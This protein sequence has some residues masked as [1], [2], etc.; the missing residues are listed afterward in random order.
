MKRKL[1]YGVF[2][3]GALAIL[4][5]DIA[6]A[7]ADGVLTVGRQ[8]DSNNLDP[9]KAAENVNLWVFA[10][11]YDVLIRVDPTGTKL[12]PGLAESWTVSDD[13]LT[14]TLKL[15]DAKFSDGSPITAED[16]A[17][18]LLRIRDHKESAWSASYSVIKDAKAA[19]DKTL[20]VTLNQPTAP[21]L[22]WLAMPSVGITQKKSVEANEAV[23]NDHPVSSG[24][25]IL[26]EWRKGERLRLE[27][28]PNYWQADKVSLDAV[29]WVSVPDDNTR[30]LNVQAGELDC[31]IFVPFSQIETLKQDPNVNMM[32]DPSSREDHLLINHS[33]G[34]LGKKEVRQALDMAI[35]E[36][37][38]VDTVTFGAGEVANSFVPKG[39]L[40]HYADNKIYPYDPDGAKKLL[41]K[42]GVK[43]LTLNYV[44]QAGNEP[45]EQTA[46][47]VQ[48][49]LAKIGVTANINK[50]DASQFFTVLVDGTY[51]LAVAYWTNDIIDPDEKVTFT[52]GH[53]SN[54]NF[55]TRYQ[56]DKVKQLVADA[57]VESD[58]AKREQMYVDLQKMAKDDVN[59]IDL[60][61]SP[62]RNVC[63]KKISGF[64]QYPLG[65]FS[66]QDV[67][68]GS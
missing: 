8:E 47:L 17:F 62:Y 1:K 41:E 7:A 53:D 33:H 2:L 23:L 42:A 12:E 46:V 6:G 5:T 67:K 25:F 40:Y 65:L 21:F 52:L 60:Y 9:V 48:Q 51:D 39:A 43:D 50:V 19:D 38:I 31:A 22:A 49:Q 3:A 4:A 32:L 28:N 30:M 58:P 14:Y 13:Q 56:N 18:N 59:F 24:P 45:D 20:V 16:A 63:G 36:K 11:M 26:T 54:L 66:F 27:K 35:D 68:K 34:D 37:A 29:E 57:R 61:Y 15:R 55:F 44:V 64:V 10:S